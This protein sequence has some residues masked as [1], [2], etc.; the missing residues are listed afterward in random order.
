MLQGQEKE[1]PD[2]Q[3]YKELLDSLEIRFSQYLGRPPLG[4]NRIKPYFSGRLYN[5]NH[6][7][8]PHKGK[9]L[10]AHV[11]RDLWHTLY[12]DEANRTVLRLN[13]MG[14]AAAPRFNAIWP[15]YTDHRHQAA[16][17][18]EFARDD[19]E[20]LAID[21]EELPQKPCAFGMGFTYSGDSPPVWLRT[22]DRPS[23][24]IEASQNLLLISIIHPFLL[25]HASDKNAL[26]KAEKTVLTQTFEARLNWHLEP[27]DPLLMRNALTGDVTRSIYLKG[28][29][30]QTTIRPSTKSYFGPDVRYSLEP[31]R[32]STYDFGSVSGR[33]R[34][35]EFFKPYPWLHE[36]DADAISDKEF[37]QRLEEQFRKDQLM[38]LAD[39]PT[40]PTIDPNTY[41]KLAPPARSEQLPEVT[42]NLVRTPAP[43]VRRLL[44]L[45]RMII[46]VSSERSSI[47][48][49]R[50]KDFVHLSRQ[51]DVIRGLLLHTDK[52]LD[53]TGRDPGSLFGD[54]VGFDLLGTPLNLAQL[55]AHAPDR[56]FEAEFLLG[57]LADDASET[58]QLLAEK[59]ELEGALVLQSPGAELSPDKKDGVTFGYHLNLTYE[60]MLDGKKKGLISHRVF[61]NGTEPDQTNFDY[62]IRMQSG[63]Y[64]DKDLE[65]LLGLDAVEHLIVRFRSG[66]V[67]RGGKFYRPKINEVFFSEWRWKQL[68]NNTIR[69][70]LE[71]G[72]V[73]IET[74]NYCFRR[75]K[76]KSWNRALAKPNA[77]DASQRRAEMRMEQV[78]KAKDRSLFSMVAHHGSDLLKINEPEWYLICDDRSREVADFVLIALDRAA[79]SGRLELI[80]VK[81]SKSKGD[82]RGVSITEYET[83]LGQ[84]TKNLRH[85][86]PAVLHARY[87]TEARNGRPGNFM[88]SRA[89]ANV[90]P[91]WTIETAP[92][93]DALSWMSNNRGHL[94]SK[95]I[96]F[97]PHQRQELWDDIVQNVSSNKG[98]GEIGMQ[99]RDAFMLSTLMF[100]AQSHAANYGA[101]F[102]VWGAARA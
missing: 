63:E 44:M 1:L 9:M 95:V 93:L 85:L 28:M 13:L 80:H 83:V 35:E 18:I 68:A 55:L 49:G 42:Q 79:Q 71:N 16:E 10:G 100:A 11:L 24:R 52:L 2:D 6:R 31:A 48:G 60:L 50:A 20:D 7:K 4:L 56:P 33:L 57:D 62:D 21:W 96:V 53:L 38:L 78:R 72:Q 98:D 89:K 101:K 61:T 36:G 91:E 70:S 69:R 97:H 15:G 3:G 58:T 26:A 81:G 86:D 41:D 74:V 19:A 90:E 34:V 47:S 51:L 14:E 75:E 84:A 40:D 29:H 25:M 102:V 54:R 30:A 67:L 92:V 94:R 12:V 17:I 77:P 99:V 43:I 39:V 45:P 65:S 88:V 87:R 59:W 5:I 64:M 46:T 32:D 22:G 37:L 82:G 76:P 66:H 8:G 27:V 73:H 23:E